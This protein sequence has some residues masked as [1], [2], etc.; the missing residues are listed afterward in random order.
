MQ[1]KQLE[2]HKIQLSSEITCGRE[3]LMESF[4]PKDFSG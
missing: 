3:C 2:Y 1:Y 4:L